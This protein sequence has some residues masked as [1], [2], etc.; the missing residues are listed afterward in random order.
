MGQDVPEQYKFSVLDI[1]NGLS[2][3]LVKSIFK[4]S[5]GFLWVGTE[6]GLNRY[7]GYKFK[8]YKYNAKDASSI[9]GNSIQKY[10]KTRRGI[11]GFRQIMV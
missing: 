2:H 4:D 8:V 1:D 11:F 6:T 9:I 7:D 10:L 5:R 3:N